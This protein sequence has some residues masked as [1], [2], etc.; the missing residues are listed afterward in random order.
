MISRQ[1]LF[2][3]FL[4]SLFIQSAWSFE[5]MQGLGFASAIS[6]ALKEL[7]R[8]DEKSLKEALKRHLVFYNAHPYMASPVLGAAVRIEE[9]AA[10]GQAGVEAAAAFKKLVMGPYGAIG[11]AFFWGSLRPLASL[12]GVVSALLWGI[13]GVVIFLAFYNVFHLWMRWQGLFKGY[14]LGEGVVGYI[15]SLDMPA[16]A[17][18]LK[19]AGAFLVGTA[20]SVMAMAIGQ[21]TAGARLIAVGLGSFAVAA[22]AAVIIN[23]LFKRGISTATVLYAVL[24]PIIIMAFISN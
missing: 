15:K 20:A 3:V 16:W 13:W 4:G 21:T 22:G 10:S 14:E 19:Y 23:F 9:K 18:R 24:F 6:P 1:A 8:G 5:K 2:Q 7:F 11:D 17:R 12:L